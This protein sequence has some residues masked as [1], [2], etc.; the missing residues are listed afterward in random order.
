MWHTPKTDAGN[1]KREKLIRTAR[2]LFAEKGYQL[3]TTRMIADIAKVTLSSVSFYFGNKEN[4]CAAVIDF[5]SELIRK[6][7]G[8]LSE[9]IRKKFENNSLTMDE[10][11]GYI[12]QLVSMQISF[13]Q[14]EHNST[15]IKLMLNEPSFPSALSG[16]LS[17]SVYE[18]IE[19][20]LA[21]LI[22]FASV[23]KDAFEAAVL[24][25]AINGAIFTFLEKP[26]LAAS[27]LPPTSKGYN[28]K[29]R[30]CLRDL[31]LSGLESHLKQ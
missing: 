15:T 28:G 10:A 29:V 18:L 6:E 3:T 25:R 12:H 14:D 16:R 2:R 7:Y 23:S 27:V 4:L 9:D 19:G 26:I 21:R 1:Q 17:Q 20:P 11:W 8:I 30:D 13:S 5:T 24:S 31:L 22:Q